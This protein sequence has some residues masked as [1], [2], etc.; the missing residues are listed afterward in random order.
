MHFLSVRSVLV[1]PLPVVIA[2]KQQ[3]RGQLVSHIP[4]HAVFGAIKR[5]VSDRQGFVANFASGETS[6]Q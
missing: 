3:S 2:G 4:S 5:A 1:L 6:C